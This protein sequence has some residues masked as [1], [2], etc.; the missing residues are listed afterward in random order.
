MDYSPKKVYFL[1]GS[2][3][4]AVLVL[5]LVVFFAREGS[6]TEKGKLI[7]VSTCPEQITYQGVVYRAKE[8]GEQCWMVENLRASNYRDG[9][10]IPNLL[11]SADWAED[12]KGAYACYYNQESY[13]NDYGAL[14]NWYAVNNEK[15]ICPEGWSVPSQEQW[16]ELERAVCQDLGYEDCQERFSDE[17]T[18]G[19]RGSDEGWYLLSAD[20]GG[21]DKYGFKAIF[22]GFRNAAGP[23]LFLEESGFWWTATETED[24]AY[25]RVMSKDNNGIRR[26]A[27]SK[28]SG[29]SVRCVMD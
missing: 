15:G 5:V 17:N 28:S 6:Q 18:L 14:Y 22:G 21:K 29:F 3:V 16:A 9:T 19:W 8:I 24:A 10:I 12:K 25:G 7:T 23:Y 27:S 1:I 11:A 26:V 13:C 2:L 20:L 4:L